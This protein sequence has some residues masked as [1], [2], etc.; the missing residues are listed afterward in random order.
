M[1]R[2]VEVLQ[3]QPQQ[4]LLVG[5]LLQMQRWMEVLQQQQQLLV[6]LL[7]QIQRGMLP[8]L[9]TAAQAGDPLPVTEQVAAGQPQQQLQGVVQRLQALQVA[10]QHRIPQ[11]CLLQWLS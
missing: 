9:I 2:W 6:G 7:L 11:W 10:T 1:Q 4:Q 8:L 5:Q 3:Q